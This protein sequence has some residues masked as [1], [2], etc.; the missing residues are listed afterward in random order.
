M[1]ILQHILYVYHTVLHS[2]VHAQSQC[3]KKV[4]CDIMH[5]M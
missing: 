5:N 3:E 4:Y 2:T 1:H